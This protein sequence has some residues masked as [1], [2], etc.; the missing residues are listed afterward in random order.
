MTTIYHYSSNLVLFILGIGVMYFSR[1]CLRGHQK[2][3]SKDLREIDH[4]FANV[5]LSYVLS[6]VA[7][8]LFFG[9][10]VYLITTANQ[11]FWVDQNFKALVLLFAVF[12][13]F[14]G[15]FAITTK[16]FPTTTKMNSDSFVYDSDGSLRW[17]AHRQITLA[18]ILIIVDFALA[19]LAK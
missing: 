9:S 17:I 13:I 2:L 12:A 8:F 5:K 1:F 18:V 19:V 3:T 6:N 16:I 10:S 11:N 15:A 14:D 7:M 4:R